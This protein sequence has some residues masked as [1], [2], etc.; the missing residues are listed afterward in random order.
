MGEEE[1]EDS[2]PFFMIDLPYEFSGLLL[3][4]GGV[5]FTFTIPPTPTQTKFFLLVRFSQLAT[6]PDPDLFNAVE[7][8]GVEVV[9]FATA[10]AAS[11]D[12]D[13]AD[14]P[15]TGLWCPWDDDIDCGA[16]ASLLPPP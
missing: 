4:E 16:S 11:D 15:T 3:P 10:A 1:E 12:D 5:P 2:H 13:A 9:P 8:G 7:G 14:S 6:S